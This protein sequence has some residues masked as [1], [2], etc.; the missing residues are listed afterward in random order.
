MELAQILKMWIDFKP[1][2]KS[3]LDEWLNKMNLW[4][5]SK[6]SLGQMKNYILELGKVVNDRVE[7]RAKAVTKIVSAYAQ[8][9][10]AFLQ[11]NKE[12][13][14]R[15]FITVNR[16]E[17][18]KLLKVSTLTHFKNGKDGSWMP[19]HIVFEM[20]ASSV[21]ARLKTGTL[22]LLGVISEVI[23]HLESVERTS[24]NRIR[25]LSTTVYE[26]VKEEKQMH[27]ELLRIKAIPKP[28]PFRV[29]ACCEK[30]EEEDKTT[31]LVKFLRCGRCR[32]TAYCSKQCQR[33]D[34][35]G[36]HNAMCK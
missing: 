19:F 17:L 4:T 9:N 15:R 3:L 13:D 1:F 5:R 29:C 2:T 31:P 18:R 28:R 8:K 26:L 25:V 36:G 21:V 20:S 27:N 30:Q 22:T 12:I 16:E 10:D 14:E 33:N 34:W 24:N 35:L 32:S 6:I 11:E 7:L 23:E